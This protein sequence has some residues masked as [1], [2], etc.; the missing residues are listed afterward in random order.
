MLTDLTCHLWNEH[1]AETHYI[2]Q[3]NAMIR[4][5]LAL[6]IPAIIAIGMIGCGDDDGPTITVNPTLKFNAGDKYTYN[7][8][9]RDSTNAR[10]E[11]SK[12]VVVWTV[13]ES[14]LS[15]LG[16]NGVAKI[17]EVRFEADG[18]TEISRS[19]VYLAI[20]LGELSQYNLFKDVVKRFST[21]QVDLSTYVGDVPDTWVIVNSTKDANARILQSNSNFFTKTITDV[22]VPLPGL[23]DPLVFD[24]TMQLGYEANQIGK[25]PV[26][27]PEGTYENAFSTDDQ[28]YVTIKNKDDIPLPI[29]TLPANSNIIKDS[30]TFH[31][32]V[33][34]E[35]GILRQTMDSKTILVAQQLPQVINGFEMEMTA[36]EKVSTE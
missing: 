25:M 6:L 29:G 2:F 4:K 8:Y 21:D 18:T 20:D 14:E 31:Y 24:A 16:E 23:P 10:V 27:V 26:T 5:T 13:L 30:V 22:T 35:S 34:V 11:S 28:V 19:T 32:D 36:V 1:I 17:E 7:Y 3:E 33:D 12:Q 9:E 15:T